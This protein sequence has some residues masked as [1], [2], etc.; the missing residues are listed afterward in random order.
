MYDLHNNP[1][2]KFKNNVELAKCLYISIV[3]VGKCLNSD[4]IYKNKYRFKVNNK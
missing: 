1:I 4:L 3:T 2:I